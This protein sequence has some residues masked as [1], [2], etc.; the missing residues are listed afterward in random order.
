[1]KYRTIV[2]DPPWPMGRTTRQRADRTFE[3]VALRYETLALAEIC[4]LPVADHAWLDCRVFLWTTNRF[5]P[6]TFD[7]LRA[8]GFKYKQTLV[9]YK[10]DPSPISGSVAPNA[11]F[12]LVGVKGSSVV[13]RRMPN[14]VLRHPQKALQ[15]SEKPEMFLD[16]VEQC[17]PGPY[18]EL[19]ARRNRLGWD[20][21]GN[22]ALEHV[23][24]EV[25]S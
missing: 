22:E 13:L 1:V 18:L 6:H 12:L 20:T 4:A 11:E 2:A 24:L 23:A 7:V 3:N 5:L 16:W 10:P 21:W 25:P 17:S 19:F 14:A 8:W 15:Q 9:W